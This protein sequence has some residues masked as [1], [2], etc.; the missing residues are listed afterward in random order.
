VTGILPPGTPLDETQIAEELNV[1]RTPV[2]EALRQLA[3][4]GLV[5]QRPHRK[6]LV[7]KPDHDALEGMFEVM[8]YLEAR[9]ASLA[10][11]RM[12]RNERSQLHAF[13]ASM[14]QIVHAGAIDDYV[15]ANETFHTMIYDGAHNAY[16]AEIS[17]STRQRLQPF[18]RAQFSSLGRLTESHAE[19]STIVEAIVRADGRA[20]ETAM[21][22][23]IGL[24]E[25]SYFRFAG[26]IDPA[27]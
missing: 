14:R 19:H 20:A 2:R 5:D 21:Y 3:S 24:V 15:I 22:A 10:A 27:S 9:C 1:S 6:A 8:S 13:H 12:S 25:E 18:R 23:H 17:R 26:Q 7:T 4:S 11:L 16:L